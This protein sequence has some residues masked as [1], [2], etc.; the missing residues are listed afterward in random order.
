MPLNVQPFEGD[1]VRIRVTDVT[2]DSSGAVTTA[3]AATYTVY[4]A[5]DTSHASG[6]LTY[7]ATLGWTA[8]FTAP[9]LTADAERLT[10]ICSITKDSSV[11]QWREQCVVRNLTTSN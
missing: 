6:N 4:R 2:H 11:R 5:D 10:V 3:D 9:T 1:S 8:I 7:D